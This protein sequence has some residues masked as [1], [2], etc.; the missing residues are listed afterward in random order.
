MK[1]GRCP[2][3]CDLP[4]EAIAPAMRRFDEARR[5]RI[6]RESLADLSNRDFEDSVA[7]KCFR[8]DGAEKCL[9]RNQ[10]ARSPEEMLEHRERFGSEL[11]RLRSFPQT[12]VGAVQ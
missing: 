12:L 10:L 6:V 7:D 8:P 1:D 4:D 5:L 2:T 3:A 11:D 9:F